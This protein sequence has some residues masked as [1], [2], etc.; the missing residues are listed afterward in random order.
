[1]RLRSLE[2][3]WLI[4][5]GLLHTY[6]SLQNDIS[7]EIAV[8]GGGITGALISHAL[9]EAGYNVVLLDKRDIAQGST[10]ATTAMLQYEIDVPLYKLNKLIGKEK[11]AACYLAGIDAIN[12]IS[13]LIEQQNIDC[14]FKRKQSLYIA[15]SNRNAKWLKEEFEERKRIGIDVSWLTKEEILSQYGLE[16]Y[17]GILSKVA[18]SIDAYKFTHELINKSVEKGLKVYDQTSI[19]KYDLKDERAKLY[20][21]QHRL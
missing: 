18:A 11:A 3:F 4:K 13:N 19:E 12:D 2:P 10:S 5:N 1:M 7:A 6:P 14:G 9:I 20:T 8:I 21:D 17:G 16:C 15:D